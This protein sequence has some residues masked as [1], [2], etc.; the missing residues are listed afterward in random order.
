MQILTTAIPLP[1]HHLKWNDAILVI[2]FKRLNVSYIVISA[3]ANPNK[4]TLFC[5]T[6][7]NFHSQGSKCNS[8]LF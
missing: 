5:M 6:F 8:R 4:K 3:T 7:N 2:R 1:F